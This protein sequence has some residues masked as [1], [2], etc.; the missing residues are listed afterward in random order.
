MVGRAV[1]RVFA[2]DT[3]DDFIDWFRVE[4]ARESAA[5]TGPQ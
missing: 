3:L 2:S 5:G 4:L 1:R